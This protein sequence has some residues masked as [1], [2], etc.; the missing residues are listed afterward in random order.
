MRWLDG[1][2]PLLSRRLKTFA[3][4]RAA[5]GWANLGGY[6]CQEPPTHALQAAVFDTAQQ[7]GITMHDTAVDY[8]RGF[9]EEGL[10]LAM[11]NSK[12]NRAT[13]RI[14]SKVL[15]QIV[16]DQSAIAYREKDLWRCP[17]P[18]QN[19]P[20]TWDW[21]YEG[22][23]R[24]AAE[25]RERL[26]VAYHDGLSLHDPAEAVREAGM[27]LDDL[28]NTALAALRDLKE[29]GQ[30]R[31]IGIG[32]KEVPIVLELLDRYPGV[33]DYLMIMN[34]NL[35]DHEQALND[36][37]PRC[38]EMGIELFLA[39]PYASGILAAPL[40][41]AGTFYYRTPSAQ[42]LAKLRVLSDL[43]HEF[44]V[45]SL[46]PVAVQFV[47][48]QPAFTRIVFGGRSPDELRENLGYMNTAIPAP[49]WKRLREVKVNGKLLIHPSA[50][51]PDE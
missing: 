16:H 12:A 33:F 4:N 26:R 38:A 49:F 14:Q 47:A 34:Y 18:Y 27:R 51:L 44:G 30:L 15:R 7:C 48:A 41:S 37:I 13:L 9:A 25:S 2:P 46:K 20:T 36:L 11:A 10:G 43:A 45:S 32:T 1:C 35:L 40:D 6:A 17:L 22:A 3:P 19:W 29:Q 39:G 31:S 42:I 24:Q 28:D 5:L 21:S 8:G 50:P 23:L